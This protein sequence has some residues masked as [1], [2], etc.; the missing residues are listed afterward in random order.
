MSATLSRS[1]AQRQAVGDDAPQALVGAVEQLLHQAVRALAGG[2]RDARRAAV[3]RD[4]GSRRGGSGVCCHWREDGV[5]LAVDL[6]RRLLDEPAVAE[7]LEQRRAASARASAV[8]PR[9]PAGSCVAGL[10]EERAQAPTS[11]F[12]ER[13]IASPSRSPGA[14]W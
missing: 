3:E 9:S 2:A 12:H 1:S 7:L 10:V 4:A 8:P 13:V 14:R 5:G 11:R 6:D